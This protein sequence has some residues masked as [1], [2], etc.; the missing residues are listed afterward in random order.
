MNRSKEFSDD[1]YATLGIKSSATA[2]EIRTAWKAAALRTHP[3]KVLDDGTQFRAVQAA[4]EIL[5]ESPPRRINNV[6]GAT[7]IKR[8]REAKTHAEEQAARK[9]EMVEQARRFLA[10]QEAKKREYE[11]GRATSAADGM[12]AR[13][14]SRYAERYRKFQDEHG[15]LPSKPSPQDKAGLE[16]GRT[17]GPMW[18]KGRDKAPRK[19][20]P[21]RPAAARRFAPELPG[22]CG[23]PPASADGDASDQLREEQQVEQQAEQQ[24][25]TPRTAEVTRVFAYLTHPDATEPLEARL[26]FVRQKGISEEHIAAAVRLAG[27]RDSLSG[28]LGGGLGAGGLDGGLSSAAAAAAADMEMDADRVQPTAADE[29]GPPAGDLSGAG[30]AEATGRQNGWWSALFEGGTQHSDSHSS[31]GEEGWL[32]WATS[33]AVAPGSDNSHPP[34]QAQGSHPSSGWSVYEA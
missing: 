27:L 16:V 19:P 7:N 29:A 30:V 4:Y 33:A 21:S 9:Q 11:W 17:K 32:P 6:K 24:E 23:Q 1:P 34:S 2:D 14:E 10:R 31:G 26:Q 28:G 8:E 18:Q 20:P 12:Q 15:A 5:R 25:Y 22:A 3:D 13:H